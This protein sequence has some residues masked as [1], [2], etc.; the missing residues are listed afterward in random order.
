M[1][2]LKRR[3][4]QDCHLQAT[5]SKRSRH[6]RLGFSCPSLPDARWVARLASGLRL[7]AISEVTE[8]NDVFDFVLQSTSITADLQR[9]PAAI[10]LRSVLQH[11]GC[12]AQWFGVPLLLF[13]GAKT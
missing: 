10:F 7:A 4:L 3:V 1:K 8:H 12:F 11:K 5:A 6:R 13:D 9:F 2:K